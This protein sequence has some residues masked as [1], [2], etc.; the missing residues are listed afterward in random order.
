MYRYVL[1]KPIMHKIWEGGDFIH[2]EESRTPTPTANLKDEL[3]EKKERIKKKLKLS[4]SE[5]EEDWPDARERKK[6]W[7]QN[8]S[9]EADEPKQ[10]GSFSIS[11]NWSCIYLKFVY[12][13]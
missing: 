2:V 12:I 13:N 4:E 8:L 3:E 9:M 1:K 6:V 5:K 10:R 11:K 7:S